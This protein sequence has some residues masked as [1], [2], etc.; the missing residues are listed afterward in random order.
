MAG[1]TAVLLIS[2][3]MV[4]QNS[5]V[6]RLQMLEGAADLVLLVLV[7][8]IMLSDRKH[9]WQL[10]IFAGLLVG[11]SSAIPWWIPVVSYTI[12][13]LAVT[14]VQRRVWQVPIWLMLT[15][16]FFGTLVIYSVEVFY[17]WITAVS[18][19]LVEVLNIVILPSVVLNMLAALP[20]YGLVGE[21][22]KRIFP[23]EVEV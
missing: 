23:K 13:V 11:L 17:L 7:S 21:I 12:F 20:V 14:Y 15:A 19:N 6:T 10:G 22:A 4:L 3:S 16:T 18:L 5:I 1:L 8:W 2:I 9:H